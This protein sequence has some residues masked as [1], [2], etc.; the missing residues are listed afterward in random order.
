MGELKKRDMLAALA[1][2]DAAA[3]QVTDEAQ[4]RGMDPWIGKT[5]DSA[6]FWAEPV[7]DAVN[8]LRKERGDATEESLM[9]EAIRRVNHEF[10][11]SPSWEVRGWR[12]VERKET[13]ER[14]FEVVVLGVDLPQEGEMLI[15]ASQRGSDS[16]EAAPTDFCECAHTRGSHTGQSCDL[17]DCNKFRLLGPG[18]T[19]LHVEEMPP[20]PESDLPER[21]AILF[22]E[23]WREEASIPDLDPA[24]IM[25]LQR[26]VSEGWRFTPPPGPGRG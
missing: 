16:P 14:V 1:G 12:E 15:P 11:D 13:G 17:C 23:A 4:A 25:A 26:L 9:H 2:L 3:E 24:E 22:L 20:P 10:G 7:R 8:A 18:M 21:P 19:K 6:R 5:L